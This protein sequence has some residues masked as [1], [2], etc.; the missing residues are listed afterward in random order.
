MGIALLSAQ[1][2]KDPACQVGC[3][4]VNP[5]KRIVGIGYNGF[6]TG[7]SDSLP[8]TSRSENSSL[9]ETKHAYVIHAEMNAIVNAINVAVLKGSTLYVTHFP[10]N[11]CTK[12][13]IQTGISRIIFLTD[14]KHDTDVMRASRRMLDLVGVKY[15]E[16]PRGGRE[17]EIWIT[18]VT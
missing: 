13:I 10:C 3:C 7:C 15:E 2:S 6:P 16:L 18:E 14:D 4:I 5:E 11:E 8:W 17:P 1:R 9:L 12:I